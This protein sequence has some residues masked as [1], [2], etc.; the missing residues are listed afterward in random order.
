[1]TA[2]LSLFALAAAAVLGTTACDRRNEVQLDPPA[3]TP[4]T[5]TTSSTA[6]GPGAGLPP[7][8][9]PSPASSASQ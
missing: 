2:R 7:P 6:P 5:G 9:P 8:S 1:M 4:A 3:D